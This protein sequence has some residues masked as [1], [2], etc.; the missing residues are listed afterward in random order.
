[1]KGANPGRSPGRDEEDEEAQHEKE[2]GHGSNLAVDEIPP[3][4]AGLPPLA[5]FLPL[6]TMAQFAEPERAPAS[7]VSDQ[8]ELVSGRYSLTG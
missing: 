6:L 8:S 2:S 7:P 3:L 5:R 1:V 4:V